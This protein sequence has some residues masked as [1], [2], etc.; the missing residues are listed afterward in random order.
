M[1]L[2]YNQIIKNSTFIGKAGNNGAFE[3]TYLSGQPVI[4]HQAG[5]TMYDGP[6]ELD[7][8]DFLNFPTQVNMVT[9]NGVQIDKTTVPIFG[10]GGSEKL[11][12]YTNKLR[13]SPDPKYRALVRK[14]TDYDPWADKHLSDTLRDRDGTLTGIANGLMVGSEDFSNAPNCIANP[15]FLGFK[16]CPASTQVGYLRILSS[17]YGGASTVQLPQVLKRSDG[18][19]SMSLT[20]INLMKTSTANIYAK[21]SLISSANY[22]YEVILVDD[23]TNLNKN[24]DLIIQYY[25]EGNID[26]LSPVVKLSGYGSQCRVN[27]AT[28][29]GSLAEL[30]S[31]SNLS[32]YASGNEFYFRIR[33]N[34]LY[35]PIVTGQAN[36]GLSRNQ[37]TGVSI[38]C[39]API[40]KS[41]TG[42]IDG[43][44]AAGNVYGWAC[45]YGSSS[46]VAIH[47][48]VG[49]PAG[50]GT[51]IKDFMANIDSEMAVGFACGDGTGTG[52]SAPARLRGDRGADRFRAESVSE[53]LRP[54]ACRGHPRRA[55]PQE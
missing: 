15:A 41:I 46:Q 36:S 10:I 9:E 35:F 54:F 55:P 16:I 33:A 32:F 22:S 25:S 50:S 6:F 11:T 52:Q 51:F 31:S 49:G 13:F 42:V 30:N 20:D 7:T 47:L 27:G 34:S 28:Q 21:T 43:V 38:T 48:Y 23:F 44:D 19:I 12:N 24:A 29:V 5:I 17:Q 45:N 4:N 2:A 40:T 37:V 18:A 14:F 53:G 3:Q 8:V 26:A 39:D 1:F